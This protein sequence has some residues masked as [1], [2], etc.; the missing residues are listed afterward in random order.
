M[1]ITVEKVDFVSVLTQDVERSRAFYTELLGLPVSNSGDTWF[2]IDTPNVTLNVTDAASIGFEFRPAISIAALRVP[3]VAE[4]RRELE[5]KGVQF[6]GETMDHG[7]CKM[8]PFAD[9][10]GNTLLLHRRYAPRD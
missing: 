5:E 9:P 4:A 2:E 6:F 10:D 8:A 7:V 1:T 3:D